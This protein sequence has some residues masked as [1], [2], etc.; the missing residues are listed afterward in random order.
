[1]KPRIYFFLMLCSVCLLQ[2]NVLA[3]MNSAP[4]DPATH[5]FN[6][7]WGNFQ[8]ELKI[9]R[10]QGKKG[11]MIFFEMDECPF[12][13][14][15]KTNVLNQ[16]GVQEYFRKNFLLF[17]LDIEGDIEITD[18]QGKH[19]SQKDFAF[20]ENRVRATP[21]IIFYDLD[22]RPVYRY[23]G[24]TAGVKEFMWLGQYVAEG[25]YREKSFVGYKKMRRQEN[26]SQKSKKQK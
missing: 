7:T 10:E 17:S 18:L 22:G 3:A 12:C 6:E 26:K 4:R 25:I 19:M 1:M 20:R 9:A 21:V 16:P 11:I 23:T 2:A 13:H 14:Y 8:E 24:R 15:M 5:F